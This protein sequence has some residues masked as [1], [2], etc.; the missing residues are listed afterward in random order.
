MER[1]PRE[2]EALD[3]RIRS[4]NLIGPAREAS[5]DIFARFAEHVR[6]GF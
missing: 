6:A 5:F 1:I 2:K 4:A 3:Q